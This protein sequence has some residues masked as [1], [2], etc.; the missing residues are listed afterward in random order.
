M[1]SIIKRGEIMLDL[2]K[3]QKQLSYNHIDTE[4]FTDWLDISLPPLELHLQQTG[5]L[6]I[7]NREKQTT[8]NIKQLADVLTIIINTQKG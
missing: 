5:E 2:T 3:I 1:A 8:H 4:Q 7:I 6:T